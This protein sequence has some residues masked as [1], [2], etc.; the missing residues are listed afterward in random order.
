MSLKFKIQN[1]DLEDF[2]VQIETDIGKK[3]GKLKANRTAKKI[4]PNPEPYQ[5]VP[6]INRTQSRYPSLPSTSE[7]STQSSPN[8]QRVCSSL[9][10]SQLIA[11]AIRACFAYLPSGTPILGI[12]LPK[13]KIDCPPINETC[14]QNRTLTETQDSGSLT[15]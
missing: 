15:S 1:R 5:A 6:T 14:F 9:G 12:Y 10:A 8:K 13:S 4:S 3:P 11:K 2:V 7:V